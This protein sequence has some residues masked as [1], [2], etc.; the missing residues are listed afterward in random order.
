MATSL[1]SSSGG[2]VTQPT[3]GMMGPPPSLAT[4][5]SGGNN[6]RPPASALPGRY[7]LPSA[8]PFMPPPPTY[9]QQQQQQEDESFFG[10]GGLL[11]ALGGGGGLPPMTHPGSTPGGGTGRSQYI[12][13]GPAPYPAPIPQRDPRR[14]FGSVTRPM[15][16]GLAA[17]ERL[18][19]FNRAPGGR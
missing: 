7:T 4:T 16:P 9:G 6:P 10:L 17:Y 5:L 3:R 12:N 14:P 13:P 8:L 18:F 1:T 19:P 2:R 15:D 11:R